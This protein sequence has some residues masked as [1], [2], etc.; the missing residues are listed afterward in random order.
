MRTPTLLYYDLTFLM[1]EIAIVQTMGCIGR[2]VH[3][4]NTARL[5]KDSMQYSLGHNRVESGISI[6]RK[7][8][9]SAPPLKIP[10]SGG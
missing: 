7:Y 10:L 1:D 8:P 2:F 3:P 4:T 9:L 5:M 6:D